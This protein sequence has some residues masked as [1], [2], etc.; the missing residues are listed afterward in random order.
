M[1]Y[2]SGVIRFNALSTNSI[3]LVK[4]LNESGYLSLIQNS[5]INKND[6]EWVNISGDV[7]CP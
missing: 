5:T 1:T 7:L 3:T 4:K 6:Y 2:T